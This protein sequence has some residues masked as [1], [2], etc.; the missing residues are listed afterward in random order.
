MKRTSRY[1]RY[2]LLLSC[3]LAAC[4]AIV[5]TYT[6]FTS[7]GPTLIHTEPSEFAR[8]WLSKISGQRS[9][10]DIRK[11]KLDVEESWHEGGPR[12]DKPLRVVMS[13]AI[14]KNPFF[15]ALRTRLNALHRRAARLG[16]GACHPRRSGTGRCRFMARRRW[17]ASWSNLFRRT[18][19]LTRGLTRSHC[20]KCATCH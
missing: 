3:A 5:A 9:L 6:L 8:S 16:H 14:V 10:V 18:L 4:F 20:C 2:A 12:L 11:Y 17:S 15:G 1:S 7:S 13:G 19:R